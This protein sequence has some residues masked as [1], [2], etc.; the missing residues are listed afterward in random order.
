MQQILSVGILLPVAHTYWGGTAITAQVLL[1]TLQAGTSPRQVLAHG[2]APKAGGAARRRPRPAAA[3]AQGYCWRKG[4]PSDLVAYCN[5]HEQCDALTLFYNGFSLNPRYSKC[6][7]SAFFKTGGGQNL[8]LATKLTLSPQ[9]V[10]YVK[11]KAWTPAPG[12]NPDAFGVRPVAGSRPVYACV[13]VCWCVPLRASGAG[14]SV[15]GRGSTRNI[16]FCLS[17]DLPPVGIG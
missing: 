13:C 12:S 6:W 15:D 9:A 11:D 10:L 16:P 4:A 1:T 8:S 2:S 5:R 3:R 17:F 7:A 14:V